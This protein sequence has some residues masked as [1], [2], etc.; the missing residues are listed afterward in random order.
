VK[1]IRIVKLVRQNKQTTHCEI[2]LC[3]LSDSLD[4]Y[5]VNLR[6]GLAGQEWRETT[7]TP[8]A[9]SLTQ[10]EQVMAEAL[11]ERMAQGFV[12][13][14]A[15]HMQAL[16]AALLP[17]A[18]AGTPAPASAPAHTHTTPPAH[19]STPPALKPTDSQLLA[20][21]PA[22]SW[23][24]L[25]QS[26]R[27]RTIWRIGE[28]RLAAGVPRMVELL[29]TGDVMQDY[30]LAWAIGRCGDG[31]AAP[32]MQVLSLRGRTDAVRRMALAAWL[33]LADATAQ[34]AHAQRLLAGW[35][36]VVRTAW[37]DANKVARLLAGGADAPHWRELALG[38]WLEQLDQIAQLAQDALPPTLAPALADSLAPAL[39]RQ[40]VLEQLRTL[41]IQSGVFRAMRHLFKMAE[42][43]HDA[44]LFGLL[45]QRF[46]LTPP[47][48]ARHDGWISLPGVR[49]HVSFAKEVRQPQARLVFG[50]A[51]RAYLRRRGWRTLRRL[52]QD[53]D[54]AFVDLALGV[55]LAL[56]D[57]AAKP[58]RSQWH[59]KTGAMRLLGPY[60]R[61][62][63]FNHLLH[64]HGAWRMAR[65]GILW[66]SLPAPAVASAREEAFPHLWD[67]RPDALLHLLLHSQC[68]GV[69]QF[70]ALALDDNQ[71]FCAQLPLATVRALLYGA[72]EASARLALRA[73]QA[74]FAQSTQS[75]P[76]RDWLLLLLQAPLAEAQQYA[77]AV[78]S[79]NPLPYCADAA[80]LA[81][82][83][84][85]QQA[86]TRHQGRLLCQAAQGLPGG[87]DWA[88][89]LLL[90]VI[91]WLEHCSD[92]DEAE[93][94]VPPVCEDLLWLIGQALP[95]AA[96]QAPHAR[97]L[98]LLAHALPCVQAL[99][100]EWLLHHQEP[101]ALI[102]VTTLIGLIQ[103]EPLPVRAVG[104]KLFGA[105]PDSLLA[106]QADLIATFCT[107]AEA[108]IRAAIDPALQ[109][110]APAYPDFAA[111][112]QRV[113]F[114]AL[115]RAETGPGMHDSLLQ[116]LQGPLAGG[117]AHGLEHG[118]QRAV[119][120]EE[121]L[122]L[123]RARSRGAQRLGA[124][125]LAGFAAQDFSVRE[126]AM[127]GKHEEVAVRQWAFAAFAAAP[128]QVAAAL[129]DGLRLLDAR[130]P[131]ARQFACEFFRQDVFAEY[132]TPTLLV[133]LCDHDAAE[134][135]RFG[136]EMITRHFELAE[137]TDYLLKLA[138]HPSQN[139]QL[140]VSNWLET[141][142]ARQP[143]CLQQLEPYFLSVLSQVNRAR[144]VKNRVL[145]FLRQQ[146][147]A[148]EAAAQVV[149]RL[150]AR[151]VVTVALGDKAQYIQGL[152]EIQSRYPHLPGLLQVHAPAQAALRH[153]A[154]T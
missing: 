89:P 29:E 141:T 110:L 131:D 52:G 119:A 151:Q 41:P 76:E 90:Q 37:P 82:I 95:A 121:V 3:Q 139:M 132:W 153:G 65:D 128:E 16:R 109:R 142:A 107:H 92:L 143:E 102:P 45:L 98:A 74:R 68:A 116:W 12:D 71:A 81:L 30:C 32:A 93:T 108:D 105:L 122:R 80:L 72:Y 149:A 137:V 54:P 42:F 125:R 146:A 70:A 150:F 53:D 94:L 129:E 99:A 31:G 134:V 86:D 84:C 63:V 28:R 62:L 154:G 66:Y 91:N 112:L 57:R 33:R 47:T 144:V 27:N 10:A 59:R 103:A 138:Q 123:L 114:D 111:S 1:L 15:A 145:A 34:Q 136:R 101:V 97:L 64:A 118:Q 6:Q 7:R 113:L 79:A 25:A 26:Y 115:F 148:S 40:I 44:E 77:L 135:Q 56:D 117:L 11:A 20:R 83:L 127:L 48:V 130:W 106:Q 17:P 38:D 96:A 49:G 9:V 126:W 23:R 50:G 19:A 124:W 13:A 35:P 100:G 55:L 14:E 21:L 58:P 60:S 69:H 73:C 104:V 2:E 22:A 75:A 87:T 85:S 51:T 140:F 39:A 43:R 24:N 61:W 88:G 8:Q 152:R 4:R 46:E 120:R 133:S 18:S 5:L 147:S 36:A 78:I 67:A